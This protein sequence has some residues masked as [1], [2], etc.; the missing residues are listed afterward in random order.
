MRSRVRA[1][2]YAAAGMAGRPGSGSQ[3]HLLG[4]LPQQG[5]W[6][7]KDRGGVWQATAHA[8]K[9]SLSQPHLPQLLL[10][11]SCSCTP[12]RALPRAVS[13]DAHHRIIITHLQSGPSMDR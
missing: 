2:V 10:S 3:G 7:H 11:S 13:S 5:R 4:V 9:T 6:T 1:C 8:R 12:R